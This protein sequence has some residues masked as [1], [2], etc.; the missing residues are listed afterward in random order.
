MSCS[1]RDIKG[2]Q[3]LSTLSSPRGCQLVLLT[4]GWWRLLCELHLSVSLVVKDCSYCIP[5]LMD[6]ASG[7]GDHRLTSGHK[8]D[9]GKTLSSP[10]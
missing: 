2:T 6:A 7:P 4:S 1:P 10:L 5:Y 3:F 9:A 8:V